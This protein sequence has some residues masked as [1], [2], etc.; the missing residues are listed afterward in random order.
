MKTYIRE[1]ALKRCNLSL[2][3]DRMGLIPLVSP[4]AFEPLFFNA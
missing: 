3:A 1:Y 4:A 2:P